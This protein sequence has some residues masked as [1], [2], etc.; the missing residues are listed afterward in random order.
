MVGLANADADCPEGLMVD[1]GCPKGLMVD[2]GCPK[3]P[4]VAVDCPK[5]LVDFCMVQ[6]SDIMLETH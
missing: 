3:G 4:M 2:V 6:T 1:V 5:G